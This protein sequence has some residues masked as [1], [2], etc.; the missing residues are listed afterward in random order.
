MGHPKSERVSISDMK[1]KLAQNTFKGMN[2]SMMLDG[3][4]SFRDD[5]HQTADVLKEEPKKC[6]IM[7]D[8]KFT[9][10][11][12][13]KYPRSPSPKGGKPIKSQRERHSVRVSRE[14]RKSDKLMN[15]SVNFV[16][17]NRDFL[18]STAN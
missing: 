1:V 10:L 4:M 7:G 13:L 3:Q 15:R 18:K 5:V 8:K 12:Q 14:I 6:F 11:N 9:C 2:A 17:Y 16:K